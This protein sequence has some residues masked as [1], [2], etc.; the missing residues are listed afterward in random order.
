MKPDFQ[1]AV[2]PTRRQLLA[3]GGLSALG[4]SLPNIL[5]AEAVR[6]KPARAKSAILVYLFGGP[7]HIDMWDMKPHA[8]KEIRGEFAPIP[9]ALPGTVYCEHLPKLAK[10][11]DR[12]TLIRT[13]THDR[14]VHGGAV[15][16]VLT[17]TRTGDPGIPGVR[18]PDASPDDHPSLG[19]AMNCFSSASGQ[20][21]TAI[22]LPWDMTDGQGRKPPGQTAAML[23][24]KFDPWLIRADPNDEKFRVEGLTLLPG[25]S[26]DRLRDRQGLL[27]LVDQQHALVDSIAAAGLMNDYYQNA[28]SILTSSAAQTA[29]DI[30]QEPAALRDRYGRN[31]FGQSCLLGR[32]LIEAGVR[33]AQVNMGNQLFGNYGWD[34]HS[35]NFPQHRDQLI[36]K[37]DPGFSTLLEDLDERGMLEDTLVIGMGEFGR[38]PRISG[39]GGRDHWPQCYSVI[40]A[41]AGI[42]RGFEL[43]RSDEHAAFPVERPVTPE[44]LIATIYDLLGI[45]PAQH[46]R[47]RLNRE[48]PLVRGDVLREVLRG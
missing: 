47:D 39:N 13:M 7:S 2:H 33:F 43:G 22:T 46:I 8:P 40:L 24:S 17:G 35:K 19:A 11:N 28:L 14:N 38:T 12:F 5:Q 31:T 16:F 18:G 44:E 4:L 37:F 23:G 6:T 27:G 48:H 26:V 30:S 3:A 42:K 36:P 9:S 10:L 41:G 29:I 32:R 20:V 15:G 34:T 21:P 25:I 45:D 1:T